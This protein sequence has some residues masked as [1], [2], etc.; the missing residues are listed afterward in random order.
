[1][2]TVKVEL[3]IPDKLLFKLMLWAHEEN[4]TLNQMVSNVVKDYVSRGL[5]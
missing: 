5:I 1:M 4:L 2:K 3:R